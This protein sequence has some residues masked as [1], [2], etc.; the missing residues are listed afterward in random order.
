MKLKRTNFYILGIVGLL[1]GL[2]GWYALGSLTLVIIWELISFPM[3]IAYSPSLD[4]H[5]IWEESE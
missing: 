5:P 3:L 2:F 1:I 4:G